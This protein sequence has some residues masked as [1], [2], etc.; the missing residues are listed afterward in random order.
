MSTFAESVAEKYIGKD[1]HVYFSD[2]VATRIFADYEWE[3]KNV[4]S[5][6]VLGAKGE[7][8][9]LEARVDE[10]KGEVCLNG[11]CVLGI[12][13]AKPDLPITYL[14]GDPMRPKKSNK[15]PRT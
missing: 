4:I 12:V 9:F 15:G 2:T 3:Q 13:E 7:C 14:F 6:K 5:G 1:V 10:F 11:Y 8:L